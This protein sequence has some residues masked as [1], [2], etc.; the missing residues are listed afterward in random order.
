MRLTLIQALEPSIEA[1]KHVPGTQLQHILET[2]RQLKEDLEES[3]LPIP[4][5]LDSLIEEASVAR[6]EYRAY[7]NGVL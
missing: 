1:L 3:N 4:E 2:L 6:D 7:F 5:D